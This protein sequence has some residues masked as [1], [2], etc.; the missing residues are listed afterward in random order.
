MA[1]QMVSL[2]AAIEGLREALT[3]AIDEGAAKG[4]QF[5]LDPIELELQAVVTK[6]ANGKIGWKVLEVGGSGESAVTQTIKLKLTPVWKTQDGKLV[7]DF[8]IAAS[9]PGGVHFGPQE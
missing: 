6:E 9:V 1:D 2:A 7:K 4:M 3:Q 8:T 5:Q